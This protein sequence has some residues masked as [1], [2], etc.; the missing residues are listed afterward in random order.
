MTEILLSEKF[1]KRVS[2][3]LVFDLEEKK[4]LKVQNSPRNMNNYD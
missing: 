2:V 3:L 4:H 1:E